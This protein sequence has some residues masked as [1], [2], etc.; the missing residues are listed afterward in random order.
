VDNECSTATLDLRRWFEL[1]EI[2][3]YVQLRPKQKGMLFRLHVDAQEKKK[4][5]MGMKQKDSYRDVR[6]S[7][8]SPF[9][10]TCVFAPA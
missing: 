5:K 7:L 10:D 3:K 6:T 2:S 9:E 8:R 4:L 1:R